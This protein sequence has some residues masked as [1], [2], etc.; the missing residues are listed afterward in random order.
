MSEFEIN[1]YILR[2]EAL[3]MAR[4]IFEEA[5]RDAGDSFDAEEL[6]DDMMDRAHE[7]ADSHNWVIY[8]FKAIMI[9]AHCDVSRGEEFLEDM[10]GIEPGETFGGTATKIAYGEMRARIE[11]ELS[12]I[13]EEWQEEHE[14]ED[15]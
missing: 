10:G 4:D 6:R 14:S 1:D 7:A 13:I 11:E 5:Q 8:T 3:G 9:C 12:E 2:Q 15:V